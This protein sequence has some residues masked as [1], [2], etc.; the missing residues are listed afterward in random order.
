MAAWVSLCV[1]SERTLDIPFVYFNRYFPRA[2]GD[3]LFCA[4]AQPGLEASTVAGS[5]LVPVRFSL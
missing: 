5:S 3:I 4:A 1:Q 2:G